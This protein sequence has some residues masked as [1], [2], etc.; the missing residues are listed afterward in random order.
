MVDLHRH[1]EFSRFDGFGKASELAILAKS[2]GHTSLAIAN[3]GNTNG[4]IKH[5]L[6]CEKHDINCILG[7]EGYFLPKYKEQTRGFHLC[8]FAKNLKGYENINRIQYVADLQKY[9]NPIWDFKILKENSEGIICTS[10]CIA[11]YVSQAIKNDKIKKAKKAIEVFKKIFGDDFYIE[12]QPYSIDEAF[13]QENINVK[14]IELAN[15]FDVKL[16]LTS[17]S[18][19]GAKDDFDSYLKM[20]EIASHNLDWVED[21]YKDRYMPTKKELMKR[22]VKMH[23]SD[24]G[25]SEAKS[26][27]LQ[28]MKNLDEIEEKVEQ[29]YLGELELKLPKMSDNVDSLKL[30]RDKVKQGLK[31]RGKWGIKKY[32]DRCQKELKV[33]EMH[34]FSDYFLMVQDY[35]L[36]AKSE[37]I[38]VGPGRGSVC[39]C[40]VAWALGITDVDSLLFDLDFRRFLREDKNKLPDVDLDFETSR[41]QEVIDYIVDKYKGK[42]AQICSYGLYKVDNLINDLAKVCGLPTDKKTTDDDEIRHNN[43]I[44]KEIK[45]YIK[46]RVNPE[47]DE[48]DYDVVK[49]ESECKLY[50]AQYDNII[51]HFSKLFKKVRFIGTHAAGVAVTSE[52]LLKYCSLTTKDGSLYT[53]YD[54]ADIDEINVV[55]FDMLGL[56]TMESIGELR[57]LTGVEGV[58]EEMIN[59]EKVYQAFSEGKTDGV[60]QFESGTARNILV[61]IKADCFE[62]I[63]AASSMNRPGPLSLRMPQQYANNKFN[64]E[65]AKLSP[66]YEYTK[67]TY[68]TIVYQEQVQLMCVEIGKLTWAEADRVMK[69]MKNAIASMGELEKINRDKEELTEKFVKGAVENGFDEKIARDMFQNILVYTFNKGH[70]AGYSLISLE[71]MYYKVYHPLKYWYSKLK[72][73]GNDADYYKFCIKAIGDG[74]IIFLPHVNYSKPKT[75]IRVVEGEECLQQGLSDIKNVGEKAAIEIYKE[76]KKNGIFT[77]FDNFYDRCSSRV[78]N[79]KVLEVL[80]SEGALEFNRNV[81]LNRVTKYNSTLYAKC[82]SK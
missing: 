41:R 71:E 10:A 29:H 30:L 18:H 23:K 28:M 48:F 75:R 64:I 62:D 50:D 5:Y 36:H 25:L 12:I 56:K 79:K 51:K 47:T 13:T 53:V 65:D 2:L 58:N 49:L 66:F 63:I 74:S 33:I 15:E 52:P 57:K 54:L 60:F 34:G 22:F 81:Y 42:A 45:S 7:V 17:D 35:V 14:L 40:Q 55:K 43:E 6:A 16:I 72:F 46:S 31:S 27:A 1:D 67:A 3:H 19:Y 76:R 8:L 78:V 44:I 61:D 38:C 82:I 70:A 20:H 68:G 77:S 32:K 11:G 24:F 59:D 9:Y 73:A 69:L 39:N 37:G 80:K 21:T 4:W 26:L